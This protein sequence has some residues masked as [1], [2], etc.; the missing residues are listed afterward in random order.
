MIKGVLYIGGGNAIRQG[1]TFASQVIL[2]SSLGE[3]AFG[4]LTVAFAVFLIMAGL[5]DLG[6]RLYAWRRVAILHGPEGA[7]EAVRLFLAR[8][9]VSLAVAILLNVGIGILAEGRVQLLLHLYTVGVVMN[10]TAFDWV[11]LSRGR[12][13]DNFWFTVASGV[14]YIAAVVLFVR[15]T[16]HVYWVPV[17][18]TASYALPGVFFLRLNLRGTSIPP[19]SFRIAP[20]E[21][22]AMV[23]GNR[24]LLAYDLLQRGYSVA[25]ILA[26]SLFYS[27]SEIARF[28]IAHLVY[29][30]VAALGIYVAAAV[31][32]R[33]AREAASRS[34]PIAVSNGVLLVLC[35][36]LPLGVFGD[37]VL[38]LPLGM[39]LG[40]GYERSFA[41]LDILIRFVALAALANFAREVTVSAGRKRLAILSYLVTIVVVVGALVV[42]HPSRLEYVAWVLVAGE[43]AGLTALLVH[44]ARAYLSR[45]AIGVG[46]LSYGFGAILLWLWSVFEESGRSSFGAY[47]LAVGLLG[48]L[49]LGYVT[50]ISFKTGLF[51]ANFH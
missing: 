24:H 43:A 17:L 39:F 34:E 11:F 48:T 1:L 51:R 19:G 4:E 49:F 25:I 30:F 37:E 36:F 32:N 16:S 6:T 15:D 29:N 23:I 12:Y 28:R 2:A 18:F 27:A 9:Q 44:D 33:V 31:F 46:I 14:I 45:K 38:A 47:A 8:L 42:H 22:V 41:V 40:E 7:R 35:F 5:G 26:A 21:L 50:T 10:Q 3:A 20:R 13:R